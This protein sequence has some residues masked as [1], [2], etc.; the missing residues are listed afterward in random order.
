MVRFYGDL[1]ASH[2]HAKR[3][4]VVVVNARRNRSR[5]LRA[6]PEKPTI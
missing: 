1:Q 5:E 4:T 3:I 6:D 2:R